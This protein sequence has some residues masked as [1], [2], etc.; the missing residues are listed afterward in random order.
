MRQVSV[1]EDR[2]SLLRLFGAECF[3]FGVMVPGTILLTVV[4]CGVGIVMLPTAIWRGDKAYSAWFQIRQ[5]WRLVDR[6]IRYI[7][8]YAF[9]PGFRREVDRQREGLR[10]KV[11][12]FQALQPFERLQHKLD[13]D[14]VD[15]EVLLGVLPHLLPFAI[16]VP[17][18]IVVSV[19]MLSV[20]G[21]WTYVERPEVQASPKP[22]AEV[23]YEPQIAD[24]QEADYGPW[25]RR[26]D[27]LDEVDDLDFINLVLLS[28][29]GSLQYSQAHAGSM[30]GFEPIS[31]P[32]VINA[33][34][35]EGQ[36]TFYDQHRNKYTV[37]PGQVFLFENYKSKAFAFNPAGELLAVD[38]EALETVELL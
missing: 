6:H 17:H 34:L 32:K 2:Q 37:N 10:E 14:Y 30:E 12:Q 28:D 38:A 23:V 36:I 11:K 13:F 5:L 4:G 19:G 8:K 24:Q 26:G 25:D 33:T 15:I 7:F 3:F 22:V 16:L 21:V 31:S 18:L 9:M 27:V 29:T 1:R 35:E 20:W